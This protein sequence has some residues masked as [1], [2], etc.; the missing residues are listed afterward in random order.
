MTTLTVPAARPE[1]GEV[2]REYFQLGK[3]QGRHLKLPSFLKF[4]QEFIT[5]IEQ[6]RHI[7]AGPGRHRESP[8]NSAYNVVEDGRRDQLKFERLAQRNQ[9]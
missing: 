8:Y 6:G 7:T 5:Y 3:H 4:S 1:P 2:M 9:A